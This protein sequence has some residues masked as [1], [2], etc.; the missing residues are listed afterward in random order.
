MSGIVWINVG[1]TAVT[2]FRFIMYTFFFDVNNKLK[3]S[4]GIWEERSDIREMLRKWGSTLRMLFIFRLVITYAICYV[5]DYE[6]NVALLF[7]SLIYCIIFLI[8]V[9]G[10]WDVKQKEKSLMENVGPV[11]IIISLI[12]LSLVVI[13]I[14]I[15]FFWV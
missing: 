12:D 13:G 10:V 8:D 5:G 7:A 3:V 4:E 11:P 1:I 14:T 9:T 2:L 6:S 15:W